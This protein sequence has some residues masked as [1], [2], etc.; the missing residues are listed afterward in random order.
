LRYQRRDVLDV[1]MLRLRQRRCVYG[2]EDLGDIRI[3][4]RRE[5]H[6]LLNPYLVEYAVDYLMNSPV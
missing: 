3:E 6:A 5:A 2:S 4:L 1:A